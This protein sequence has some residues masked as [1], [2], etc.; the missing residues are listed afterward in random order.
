MKEIRSE[1]YNRRV[2]PQRQ[3]ALRG[4]EEAVAF[5]ATYRF[6]MTDE[7]LQLLAAVEAMPENRDGSEKGHVWRAVQAYREFFRLAHPA[8]RA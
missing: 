2:D 1:A 5:A 8:A 4:L 7:Y 3:Q 6:Q